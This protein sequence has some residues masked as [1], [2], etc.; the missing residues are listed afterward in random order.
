MYSHFQGMLRNK[1]NEKKINEKKINEKK[2]NEKINKG[3]SPKTLRKN[4]SND[5]FM[6]FQWAWTL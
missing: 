2:T 1:I 4:I 5:N 3:M 6:K